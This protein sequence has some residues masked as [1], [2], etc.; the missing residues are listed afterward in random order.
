MSMYETLSEV[1]GLGHV[2]LC[3]NCADVHVTIGHTSF[4]LPLTAFRQLHQ[5]IQDAEDHPLLNAGTDSPDPVFFED[6]F[7]YIKPMFEQ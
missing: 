7:P 3:R 5:M 2:V 6:G 1:P 4:R